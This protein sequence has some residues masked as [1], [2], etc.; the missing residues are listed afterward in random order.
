MLCLLRLLCHAAL[1]YRQLHHGMKKNNMSHIMLC[2][3]MPCQ[4]MPCHASALLLVTAHWCQQ[5]RAQ[6]APLPLLPLQTGVAVAS[7]AGFAGGLLAGLI[8]PF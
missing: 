2:N 4:A 7:F 1:F 8:L 5:A 6:E 3:S